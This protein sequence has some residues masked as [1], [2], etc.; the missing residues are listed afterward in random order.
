MGITLK[1]VAKLTGFSA[2][3]VSRVLSGNPRISEQ[4]RRLVL[5]GVG[6]T[7]YRMN[8]VAR[9]LKTRKTHTVGMIVP[10]LGDEFF[11]KVARGVEEELNRNGFH[12]LIC[13]S[14]ES[15]AQERQRIDLLIQKRVDGL[16]LIPS[17]GSGSHLRVINRAG[18]PCVLVD[19]L[20]RG[21][22]ADM[23]VVDNKRGACEAVKRL[24]AGGDNRIGFI[25]AD[26]SISTARD[27]YLGYLDALRESGIA[28]EEGIVR[29]GDFHIESGYALMRELMEGDDPPESLFIANCYMYLGAARYLLESGLI[30]KRRFSIAHFDEL[31]STPVIQ[32]AKIAVAQPAPEIGSEAVRLLLSRI[33]G[34]KP[35]ATRTVELK[36][37]L[38]SLEH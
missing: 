17:T 35:R 26:L 2:S 24:V 25:G 1:D 5:R 14:H 15:A 9:S 21:F 18:I 20:V 34:A 8:D 30:G 4:T 3:T 27:R 23:V 31:S 6:K 32:L 28:P 11:M 33:H 36:T 16:V 22:K 12:L 19:R 37:R 10:Q 7:G 13:N 38:V 29:F